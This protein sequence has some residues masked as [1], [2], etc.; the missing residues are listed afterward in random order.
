MSG[1]YGV[2]FTKAVASGNDFVI[3]DNR[4]GEISERRYPEMAR[5]VSR[6]RHSIGADGMLVAESSEKAALRMR[7]INPDGSE[8]EMCGNGARCMALYAFTKGLGE[9]LDIETG[10][11][12]IGASVKGGNVSIK[13]SDP[14]DIKL[15]I[16]IELEG[17]MARVHYVNSGV[18]HVVRIS[19]DI[20]AVNVPVTG[21]A[22]R[23]HPEFMPE[24]ANADFVEKTGPD[25]ASVRTYERGVEDE[26]LACGTGAVASAIVLAL[27]EKA[28]SPVKIRTRSGEVL[29]I[30]FDGPVDGPV[31]NVYLEGEAKIVFDGEV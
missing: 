14:R 23:R 6:R 3:V 20:D 8:A 11:G 5:D 28:P 22:I 21:R 13:M 9:V 12:I 30:H 17:R 15:N 31:K 29:T 2:R 1:K 19:E 24:G 4:S 26:T 16:D 18:P 7:I 25:A 10:A 27:T